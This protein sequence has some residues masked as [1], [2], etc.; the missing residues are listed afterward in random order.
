MKV[1]LEQKK[2]Q[3]TTMEEK[4]QVKVISIAES[5]LNFRV[6]GMVDWATK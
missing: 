5:D 4:F 2:L 3:P 6:H 1:C